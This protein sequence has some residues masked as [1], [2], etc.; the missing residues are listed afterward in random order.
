MTFR[1]A[2]QASS[3]GVITAVSALLAVAA[4]RAETPDVQALDR[5]IEQLRAEVLQLNVEA[6]R[7]E[8]DL[9]YPAATRTDFYLGVDISPLLIESVVLTVADRPPLT[10]HLSESEATALLTTGGLQRV[11][12]TNLGSGSHRIQVELRGSYAVRGEEKLPFEGFYE[13]TFERGLTSGEIELNLT[14][15]P[16]SSKPTLVL[17]SLKASQP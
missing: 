15:P 16:R 3:A 14:R 11:A 12:R 1:P 8:D 6:T 5:S 4:A 7:T 9:L 2:F 10:H 13:A 17:R